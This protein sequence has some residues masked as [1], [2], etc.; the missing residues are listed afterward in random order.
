MP[1][2]DYFDLRITDGGT[3][4]WSRRCHDPTRSS[5]AQIAAELADLILQLR[6]QRCL[7]HY[8]A[9][10]AAVDGGAPP[11]GASAAALR[12]F[13]QPAVGLPTDP[14]PRPEDHLEGF[15]AEHLWYFLALEASD[16]EPV[17]HVEPPGFSVTDQGGDGL[18][19]HR[20][21]SGALMYRLWEIKK[22]AGNA[23]VSATVSRAYNQLDEKA[24]RYLARYTAIGQE[25]E[26]DLS[27]IYGNLIDLWIEGDPSAALGISVAT[28]THQVPKKCFTTLGTRFPQFA[29]P[30]RLRGMVTSL[31]DF[32]AFAREVRDCL[33]KGL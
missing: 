25:L 15:V 19:I 16:W 22:T 33:W 3:H 14:E 32:P 1:L 9:W 5:A 2:S 21:Q 26:E 18:I 10:R 28:S 17:V 23:T 7:R 12:A 6:C 13:I 27:E 29:S 11:T 30:V 4:I 31:G 24:T 8:R 20:S